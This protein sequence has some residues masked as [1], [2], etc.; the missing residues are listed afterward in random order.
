MA[1]TV[2]IPNAP[3]AAVATA[4]GIQTSSPPG[5][6]RLAPVVTRVDM[7]TPWAILGGDRIR[8]ARQAHGGGP[9]SVVARYHPVSVS[10][11][12]SRVAIDPGSRRDQ[13]RGR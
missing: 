3:M 1:S 6:K 8:H 9:A 10:S 4:A 11:V 7:P 12:P 5:P 2:A 13:G